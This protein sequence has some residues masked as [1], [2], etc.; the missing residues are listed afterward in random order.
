MFIPGPL[1]RCLLWARVRQNPA[2]STVGPDCQD[3][4]GRHGQFC[5]R[6]SKQLST[7]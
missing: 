3:L 2:N 5:C 4:W 7:S 6:L 1:L